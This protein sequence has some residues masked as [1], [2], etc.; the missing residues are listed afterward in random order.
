MPPHAC[1]PPTRKKLALT[2]EKTVEGLSSELHGM[3]E[4]LAMAR[5]GKI[6]PL[7]AGKLA[8]S[9]LEATEIV[10]VSDPLFKFFVYGTVADELSRTGSPMELTLRYRQYLNSTRPVEGLNSSQSQMLKHVKTCGIDALR[11]AEELQAMFYGEEHKQTILLRRQAE[12]ALR[13][14]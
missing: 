14:A 3:A 13:F 8:I 10:R 6:S 11:R 2:E 12:S 1:W 5:E 7:L 4:F 9:L